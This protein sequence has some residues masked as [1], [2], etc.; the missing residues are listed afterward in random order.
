MKASEH[1]IEKLIPQREPMVLIDSLVHADERKTTSRFLIKET[2]FFVTNNRIGEPGLIENIAQTAAAGFGYNC[3]K[4]GS[5]IVTGFLGGIRNLKIH[6]LPK[7]NAEL[8]TTTNI[9]NDFYGMLLVKGE[10]FVD[11]KCITECQM[12]FI[13]V[14]NEE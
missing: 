6:E 4:E 10:I 14:T 13:I 8:E 11:K 5:E 1:E 2:S 9:E 3:Q 12:K 7:I